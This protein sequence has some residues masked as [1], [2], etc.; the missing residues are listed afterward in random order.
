[1]AKEGNLDKI[2]GKV[3]NRVAGVIGKMTEKTAHEKPFGMKPVSKSEQLQRYL[4]LSQQDVMV[5]SQEMGVKF[6][7]FAKEMEDLYMKQGMGR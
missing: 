7:S 5:L 1:M 4:K 6:L 3:E 2:K